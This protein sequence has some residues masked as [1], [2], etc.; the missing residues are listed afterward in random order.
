MPISFDSPFPALSCLKALISGFACFCALVGGIQSA[1]AASYALVV[2][3]NEYQAEN[4]LDGA[5]A[6]AQDIASALRSYGVDELVLLLNQDASRDAIKTNLNRMINAASPGDSLIFTY[7]GHGAQAPEA[8]AGS[9]PDGKDEFFLL[10]AF[11]RTKPE[12]MKNNQIL[13]D[14]IRK[15]LLVADRKKLNT[16]F[17]ADS[18]HSGGMSRS[19]LKSRLAPAVNVPVGANND[20]ALAASRIKEKDFRNT[21][22][23]SASLESDPA[24]EVWIDGAARGALSYAFA[25]ALRPENGAGLDKNGNGRIERLELTDYVLGLVKARAENMQTANFSPRSE[26]VLR[27]VAFEKTPKAGTGAAI[28]Q[29]ESF[30]LADPRDQQASFE[31]EI[32]KIPFEDPSSAG[33][34]EGVFAHADHAFRWDASDGRMITPFGDIAASGLKPS[35]LQQVIDKFR[36]I[37]A[38]KNLQTR[39]G[40]VSINLLPFSPLYKRG[41]RISLS[42]EGVHEG[43]ISLFNLPNDGTVQPL[44]TYSAKARQLISLGDFEIVPPFGADHVVALAAD[45]F[46]TKAIDD[47]FSTIPDMTATDLLAR[48]PSLSAKAKIGIQ[49]FYTKDRP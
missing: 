43:Q 28:E 13:D 10:S 41:E 25:M 39:N 49:P 5:V 40:T 34:I 30:S 15:W 45:D 42:V 1:T 33:A 22:F 37:E 36:L 6:D 32:P 47:L 21:L 7:A 44:G 48:L 11:D 19:I 8:I 23:L 3:I 17:V 2:G 31:T 9:E 46:T 20:A 14:E 16:I 35:Q 38:L 24:P 12:E 18:C 27:A 4:N 26:N 29:L